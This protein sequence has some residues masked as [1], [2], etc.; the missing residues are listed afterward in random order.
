M[1]KHDNTDEAFMRVRMIDRRFDYSGVSYSGK[2]KR[3]K[4]QSF[5]KYPIEEM[6]KPLTKEQRH[7]RNQETLS[8]D[9][10]A[11]FGIMETD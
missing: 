5:T 11:K 8:K 3:E 1:K 9:S 2:L 10:T 4:K 7:K 6:Q